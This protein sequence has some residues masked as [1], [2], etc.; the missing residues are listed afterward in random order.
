[1]DIKAAE[2]M[3]R[4]REKRS[5]VRLGRVASSGN[6]LAELEIPPWQAN[7]TGIN[8]L[9]HPWDA[10]SHSSQKI[11]TFTVSAADRVRAETRL[12]LALCSFIPQ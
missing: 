2:K 12:P 10:D 9:S 7:P 1:M 11:T 5:E 4:A 8:E 3:K 6:R